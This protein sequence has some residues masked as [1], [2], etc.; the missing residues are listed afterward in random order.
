MTNTRPCIHPTCRDE[1]GNARLTQDVMCYRCRSHYRR[2]LGWLI[3]DFV[4]V[5]S[6]MLHPEKLEGLDIHGSSESYGHP[7]EWASTMADEISKL[8]YDAEDS[9][10]SHLEDIPAA[11]VT[12]EARKVN[13]AQTYISPRFDQ[14]CTFPDAEIFAVSIVDL[15]NEIFGAMGRNRRARTLP[16]PCPTCDAVSLVQEMGQ[17]TCEN[18]QCRRVIREEDYPFL[19]RIAADWRLDELVKEYDEA[20]ASTPT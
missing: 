20:H 4:L 7:A 1:D 18:D 16:M 11:F 5:K 14:F 17:I 8:L 6:A 10:R 12:T 15:H 13:N 2:Q 19:A 9:L 3:E